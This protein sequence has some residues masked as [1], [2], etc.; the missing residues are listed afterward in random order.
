MACNNQCNK[1]CTDIE[2]QELSELPVDNLD[3]LPDF[4][5]TE[6]TVLDESTGK[7]LHALTRTP[8][9]TLIPN[10]N[11]A[12]C[13]TLDGNNP[14]LVITPNQPL[15]AYIQNNGATNVVYAA[16]ANHKADFLVVGTVGDLLL[17]QNC[18]VVNTLGGNTYIAGA[19]YYLSSTA[20][21]VTTDAS[22]TGQALF[23]VFSSTKLG[24][25]L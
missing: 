6:R 5:L 25:L 18:G 2:V 7:V 22:Q 16:D 10:G 12:N 24:I 11:Y 8:T 15:P 23:K 21:E 1:T 19:T 20:G 4:V 9:N 3:T 13:F 14:D 17:C